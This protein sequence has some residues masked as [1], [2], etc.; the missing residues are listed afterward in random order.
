MDS[1]TFAKV[2]DNP[3]Q[4]L[5]ITLPTLTAR[6]Q[7]LQTANGVTVVDKPSDPSTEP[8]PIP[9]IAWWWDDPG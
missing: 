6:Y 4:A 2:Y 1:S 9:T 5:H 8:L 3:R 7:Y